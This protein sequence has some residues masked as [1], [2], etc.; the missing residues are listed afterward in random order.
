MVQAALGTLSVTP[1]CP[2]E[3]LAAG[4]AGADQPAVHVTA[5]AGAADPEQLLA[6]GADGQPADRVLC[7]PSPPERQAAATSKTSGNVRQSEAGEQRLP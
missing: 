1:A 3:A 4:Q 5:I 6:T 7:H 2:A